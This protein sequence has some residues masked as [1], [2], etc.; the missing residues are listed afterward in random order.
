MKTWDGI[1]L[2]QGVPD[3]A[4]LKKDPT[5]RKLVVLDDLMNKMKNDGDLLEMFTQGA[6]HWGMSVVFITQA[7]FF[8]DRTNRRN[9]HY[10]AIFNSP[11]DKLQVSTFARQ[12]LPYNTKHFMCAYSDA[13]SLCKH[14]YLFIDCTQDTDDECRLCTNVFPGQLPI[15]YVPVQ[16]GKK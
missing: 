11:A 1:T 2:I 5:I 8:G 13:V 15:V 16:K 9:S 6:H 4:G 12:M 3:T 10:L 14:H 7:L